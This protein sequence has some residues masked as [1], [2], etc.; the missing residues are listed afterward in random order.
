MTFNH[1]TIC[2][3]EQK[4]PNPICPSSFEEP[5][6]ELRIARHWDDPIWGPNEVFETIS[7]IKRNGVVL[8]FGVLCSVALFVQS[9]VGTQINFSLDNSTSLG[10]WAQLG[11]W[12]IG[13]GVEINGTSTP[14]GVAWP[15]CWSQDLLGSVWT[16]LVVECFDSRL[17][18][19]WLDRLARFWFGFW[20]R[21]G[22]ARANPLAI[23]LAPSTWLCT[24]QSATC[25]AMLV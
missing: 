7:R 8:C 6:D 20:F 11:V 2:K 13:A 23:D 9:N 5:R 16:G 14:S 10:I 4:L 24:Y 19:D 1:V 12:D 25:W 3:N 18:Y 21:S 17:W 22:R 15:K